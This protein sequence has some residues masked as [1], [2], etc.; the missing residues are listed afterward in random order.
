MLKV[1]RGYEVKVYNDIKNLNRVKVGFPIIGEYSFFVVIE[2]E[3]K[4]ILYRT[5]DSLKA[6]PEV[7]S[8][9]HILVSKD[10]NSSYTETMFPEVNLSAKI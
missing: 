6:I 8:I 2:A 7:T 3:N 10:S 9:W 1:L 5:I 4:S